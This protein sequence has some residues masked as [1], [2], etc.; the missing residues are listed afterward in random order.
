M[1]HSESDSIRYVHPRVYDLLHFGWSDYH[2]E[3]MIST[4]QQVLNLCEHRRPRA[5]VHSPAFTLR[6][7]LAR[8]SQAVANLRGLNITGILGGHTMHCSVGACALLSVPRITWHLPR[9]F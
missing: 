1:Q 6:H 3:V 5:D 2:L 4:L 7:C 9:F 8:T